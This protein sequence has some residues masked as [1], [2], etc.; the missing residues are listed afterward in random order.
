MTN[1]SGPKLISRL[2]E[3]LLSL[4][5]NENGNMAVMGA[6]TL[7]PILFAAGAAVDYSQVSRIQSDLQDSLD[8]A[9]LATLITDKDT[10]AEKIAFGQSIF[11]ANITNPCAPNAVIQ[12]DGDTATASLSCSVPTTLLSLA[13]INNI[14]VKASATA[15]MNERKPV[16]VLALNKN[17]TN[18]IHTWGSSAHIDAQD[19]VVHAN[20]TSSSALR[21]TSGTKS[22]A[23]G[24]CAVG[25]YTGSGFSPTPESD[26]RKVDDPYANLPKPNTNGCDHTNYKSS[27]NDVLNPG[28][29]C[30]GMTIKS[31]NLQINSGV[32]VLKDGPLIISTSDEVVGLGVTFYFYGNNSHLNIKGNTKVDFTAPT[33]GVYE[34]MVFV[35]HP[36]ADPGYENTINGGSSAR[37]VGVGYFPT[38]TLSI[39][40]SGTMGATSPFMMFV[41]DKL[42]FSG[43]GQLK[44]NMD[45]EA[46]GFSNLALPRG[47]N[48]VRL[49]K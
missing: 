39:G 22:K 46:A 34:G 49:I 9:V 25:S 38:Q 20:S 19:C 13:R 36:D 26:C 43:N 29:Y 15:V 21:S 42:K 2:K 45:K 24:F 16:C 4:K 3:T 1:A 30:G 35:Q 12:I 31:A 44:L 48:G 7:L 10:D 37:I 40:G 17:S 32:Y 23:L 18:S 47:Y 28:V 41:T 11:K 5:N 33:S 6:V 14:E 27:D 8:A